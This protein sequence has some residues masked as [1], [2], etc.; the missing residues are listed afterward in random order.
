LGGGSASFDA[1]K[2]GGGFENHAVNGLLRQMHLVEPDTAFVSRLGLLHGNE[3]PVL[4]FHGIT[5]AL[6]VAGLVGLVVHFAVGVMQ[7]L[8]Q[9]SPAC[10]AAD[11]GDGIVMGK[12]AAEGRAARA[13]ADISGSSGHG[14]AAREQANGAGKRNEL[15]Q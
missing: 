13:Q 4:L 15:D 6:V 14:G 3:N 12:L 11:D 1:E 7:P 9:L 10:R 8:A 5:T 2:L